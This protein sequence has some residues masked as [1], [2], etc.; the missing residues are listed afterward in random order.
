[1]TGP[2]TLDTGQYVYCSPKG[3][4]LYAKHLQPK[5]LCLICITRY[6][7]PNPSDADRGRMVGPGRPEA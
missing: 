7:Q 6:T 4:I 5:W 3:S 1:M 2:W